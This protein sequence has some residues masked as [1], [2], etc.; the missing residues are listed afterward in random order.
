MTL[1]LRRMVFKQGEFGSGNIYII[2]YFKQFP[3]FYRLI[4]I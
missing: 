4:L 2:A 1:E 3:Y